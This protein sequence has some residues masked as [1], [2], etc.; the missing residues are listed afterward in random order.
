MSTLS[1]HIVGSQDYSTLKG[2]VAPWKIAGVGNIQGIWYLVVPE[3][4][5]AFTA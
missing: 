5:K 2:T 4:K 1:T 3:R